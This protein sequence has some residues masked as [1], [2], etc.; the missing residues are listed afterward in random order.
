MSDPMPA[1]SASLLM[2][3]TITTQTSSY[4]SGAPELHPAI[5]DFIDTLPGEVAQK[6]SGNCAEVG[7]ISDRLWMLDEQR[8]EGISTIDDVATD[9]EGAALAPR[10][11]RE[12]GSP[13]HGKFAQPCRVCSALT[14]RL[15]IRIIRPGAG[16]K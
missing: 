10:M 7:L 3:G 16:A 8:G 4:G 6:F 12:Q 15:G 1:V 9:F 14:D 5:L 13:E 2:G 11:V